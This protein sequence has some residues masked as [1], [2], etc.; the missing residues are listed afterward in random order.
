M[1][2]A[3]WEILEDSS[4]HAPASKKLDL[5]MEDSDPGWGVWVVRNLSTGPGVA[6]ELVL[7]LE[8]HCMK[9]LSEQ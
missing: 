8:A 3:L 4:R 2:P 6:P 5:E 1:C 9:A 7:G